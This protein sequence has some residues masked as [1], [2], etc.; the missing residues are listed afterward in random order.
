MKPVDRREQRMHRPWLAPRTGGYSAVEKVPPSS[1]DPAPPPSGR[2]AAAIPRCC[3]CRCQH[4]ELIEPFFEAAKGL[5]TRLQ[6]DGWTPESAEKIAA[7]WLTQ[8]LAP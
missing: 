7:A 5:R 2:A 1:V 6:A 4:L 3:R 8:K